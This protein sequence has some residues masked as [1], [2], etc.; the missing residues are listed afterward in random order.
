MLWIGNCRY[1][2]YELSAVWSHPEM[3]A[4]REPQKRHKSQTMELETKQSVCK[5]GLLATDNLGGMYVIRVRTTR[6]IRVVRF[7]T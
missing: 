4:L 7:Q 2:I 3:I 6:L 1:E 5:D